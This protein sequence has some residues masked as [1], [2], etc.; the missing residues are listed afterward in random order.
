VERARLY[1]HHFFFRRS[2]PVPL[3]L[4]NSGEDSAIVT[5]NTLDEL[6]PGKDPAIDVICTGILEGTHFV[7][8]A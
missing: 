4:G 7:Y 3:E 8:A 5:L 2:I 6:R 1:A